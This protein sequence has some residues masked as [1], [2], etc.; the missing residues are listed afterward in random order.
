VTAPSIPGVGNAGG[1]F[2]P[3][4]VILDE[5][6]NEEGDLT[7]QNPSHLASASVKSVISHRWLESTGRFAG[8]M[9]TFWERTVKGFLD[10]NQNRPTADGLA[11]DVVVALIDDG[12]DRFNTP[13]EAN[14][15]LDGKSFD[16]HDRMVRPSYSSAKGHGTVMA[17]MILRVCPMAKIYPIRLKTYNDSVEGKNSRIDAGY[18]AQVCT[19]IIR[20]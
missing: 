19:I 2:Y 20:R 4:E 15:V 1:E 10:L 5:R 11:S 7:S 16:F 13:L 14:R 6:A 18:A 17:S 8:Q 9:T 3:V 12:V